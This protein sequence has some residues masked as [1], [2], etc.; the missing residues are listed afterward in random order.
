MIAKVGINGFLLIGR[1]AL[2][3]IKVEDFAC[4]LSRNAKLAKKPVRMKL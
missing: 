3:A 1:M 4:Q 2:G